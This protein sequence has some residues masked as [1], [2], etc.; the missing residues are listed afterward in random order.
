MV[1][2]RAKSQLNERARVGHLLALPAVIGLV[3]AHGFFAG[4]VPRARGFAVQIVLADQSFLNSL[5]TLRINFLLA[6]DAR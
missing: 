6:A 1:L 2:A 4:L 3:A 5:S